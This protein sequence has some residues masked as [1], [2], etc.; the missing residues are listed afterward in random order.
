MGTWG[1]RA[2]GLSFEFEDSALA[3]SGR[4]P[5]L[6]RFLGHQC[7]PEPQGRESGSALSPGWPSQ[8]AGL[9]EAAPHPAIVLSHLCGLPPPLQAPECPKAPVGPS[10]VSVSHRRLGT[11]PAQPRQ[12]VA[13]T[14]SF[15]VPAL[16]SCCHLSP[17]LLQPCCRE[18]LRPPWEGAVVSVPP[19]G[20][21]PSSVP[22]SR[23]SRSEN[24]LFSVKLPWERRL[25][26]GWLG[27]VHFP[28]PSERL[29]ASG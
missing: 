18:P 9:P 14:L 15:L 5:A 17:H 24:G 3:A 26:W 22:P 25:F 7:V 2:E 23:S 6:R 29:L 16:P 21:G 12:G 13:D 20:K 28:E 19:L 27:G 1:V 8:L 4:W 11:G 10:V